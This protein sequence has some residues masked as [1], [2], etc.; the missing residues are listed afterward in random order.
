MHL[1]LDK[2]EPGVPVNICT[3]TAYRIEDCLR[4]L[5]EISGLKVQLLA[6]P[7]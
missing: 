3:G 4:I 5:I 6:D 7:S 2:G 1:L